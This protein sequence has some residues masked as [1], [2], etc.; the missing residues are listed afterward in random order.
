MRKHRFQL[1]TAQLKTLVRFE[2]QTLDSL[3]RRRSH[4]HELV[5]RQQEEERQALRDALATLL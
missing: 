3:A 1:P 4:K 2:L 5:L